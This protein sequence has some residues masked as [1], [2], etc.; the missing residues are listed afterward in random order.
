MA[1]I[2]ELLA[3]SKPMVKSVPNKSLS[4]V[5]G[6]P[7]TGKPNSREKTSAPLNVPSPPITMSASPSAAFRLSKAFRRSEEHTSELQSLIRISYAVFCLKTQ[8]HLHINH[9]YIKMTQ[10]AQNITTTNH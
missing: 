2:T 9:H 6:I 7:M 8:Q 5:P 10:Q 3:V 4:M 1:W